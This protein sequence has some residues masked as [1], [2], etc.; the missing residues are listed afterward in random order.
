MI[1]SGVSDVTVTA[2]ATS[3]GLSSLAT[4]TKDVKFVSGA[5]TPTFTV[6][7]N[8]VN[9]QTTTVDSVTLTF[10]E[11]VSANEIIVQFPANSAQNGGTTVGTT[12]D[13]KVLNVY[14]NTTKLSAANNNFSISYKGKTYNFIYNASTGAVTV[15]AS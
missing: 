6:N 12:A 1:S 3:D 5:T 9:G 13:N 11:A 10:T 2:T 15:Q 7:A 4:I 8:V 14:F